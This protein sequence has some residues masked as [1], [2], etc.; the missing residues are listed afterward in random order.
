MSGYNGQGYTQKNR[1]TKSYPLKPLCFL[2]A[3]NYAPDN[4]FYFQQ[5][6][7]RFILMFYLAC[8]SVEQKNTGFFRGDDACIVSVFFLTINFYKLEEQ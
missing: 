6:D 2:Y 4:L 7:Q 5:F 3:L 8:M 1:E